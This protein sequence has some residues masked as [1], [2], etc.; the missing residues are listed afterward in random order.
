MCN[1]VRLLEEYHSC[2]SLSLEGIAQEVGL[3]FFHFLRRFKQEIG[4]TPGHYLRQQRL[5]HALQLLFSTR[6]SIEEISYQSGFGT[7]RQLT[8]ACKAV[9]GQSPSLLRKTSGFFFLLPPPS[10]SLPFQ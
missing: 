10:C 1:A 2:S 7:S 8:E 4:V 3:S 6:L 5:N 9:F